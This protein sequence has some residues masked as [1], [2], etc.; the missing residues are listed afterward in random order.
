MILQI[1]QEGLDNKN[2]II[3]SNLVPIR[4]K[5]IAQISSADPNT[6]FYYDF[7]RIKGINTSGVDEIIVKV[8]QHIIKNEKDKYLFLCNL[9]EE[10]Y[11]HRFNINHPLNKLEIAV[12]EKTNENKVEFLGKVS[13]THRELLNE[14]YNNKLVTAR[15]LAD[16]LDKKISLLSTHL[17]KLYTNRLIKR[18]EELL[19]DGGRQYVYESIF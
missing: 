10:L 11:E 18:R 1:E 7:T 9:Q 8:V 14:V 5:I 4:E 16:K 3:R 19:P 15:M 13:D 17:N 2:L 6:V 12:V